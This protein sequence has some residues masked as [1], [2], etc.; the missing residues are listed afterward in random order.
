M[1]TTARPDSARDG[2][3][4]YTHVTVMKKNETVKIE[5]APHRVGLRVEV[6]GEADFPATLAY[7]LNISS[8]LKSRKAQG[9][10]L[11]DTTTGE[12]LSAEQWTFLVDAMI[13]RGFE[14]VR[15]AHVKPRGLERVEFCE[16]CAREHGMQARVF[17]DEA[18]AELWMRYGEQSP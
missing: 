11:I 13:G 16:L 5:F 12:S 6:S 1:Q 10:L 2:V 4:N 14:H 15:I 18:E 17:T 7:W 3:N 8:E 9:L